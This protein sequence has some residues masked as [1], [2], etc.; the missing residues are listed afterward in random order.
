MKDTKQKIEKRISELTAAQAAMLGKKK[1]ERDAAAL[2]T[3]RTEL[4]G[5][6][7]AAAALYRGN[8]LS[9]EQNAIVAK[10]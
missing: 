6:K 4:N 3:I 2:A 5:L 10:Y 8:A 9:E 1:A 7:S